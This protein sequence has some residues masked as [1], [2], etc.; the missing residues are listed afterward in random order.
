MTYLRPTLAAV[1]LAAAAVACSEEPEPTPNGEGHDD[2][3]AARVASYI[4]GDAQTRLRL[5]LDVAQGHDPDDELLD[6]LVSRFAP[7]LDKPDGVAFA[8]DEVLEAAP[9]RAWTFDELEG[10]ADEHYG[11]PEADDEAVIHV[12]ILDGHY[13]E[14][15]SSNGTLGLA[16]GNR[17][18]VLFSETLRDLCEPSQNEELR[19]RGLVERA[20][21]AS[22]TG[23]ML[24]ELGHTIGLVNNG[25]DM[26][27]PHN[28]PDHPTHSDDP[29]SIMHWQFDVA[30][31][32]DLVKGKLLDDVDPIP[33]FSEGCLADV[34]ALRDAE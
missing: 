12:M 19:K 33:P 23:T 1:A 25:L 31:T 18:V 8:R 5:E 4:R 14:S 28:D 30:G 27:T 24:H 16:W 3:A 7:L 6:D 22:F 20:C 13:A 29:E 2:V 11:G 10:F 34:A 9:G 17:H 15:A 21:D 32:F 26:V